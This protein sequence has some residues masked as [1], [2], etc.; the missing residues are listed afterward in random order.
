MNEKKP[1]DEK[2]ANALL[3]A[4]QR[5]RDQAMNANA[6]LEANLEQLGDQLKALQAELD[7][8]KPPPD[9]DPPPPTPPE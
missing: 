7:K 5:Q 4:M 2:Y 8:F 9:A 1:M 3:Q 6:F